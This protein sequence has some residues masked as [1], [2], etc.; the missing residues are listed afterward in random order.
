MGG[1]NE[2]SA[3]FATRNPWDLSRVPGGSSGGSAAAVAARM[4]PL[5]LG[6]DTGGSIRGPAALCGITGLKPTYGRVSRYGVMPRAW[7]LDHVGPIARSARD[8]ARLLA[9]IAGP[10]ANDSTASGRPVPRSDA[11]FGSKRI[12]GIAIGVPGDAALGD[13]HPEIAAALV[14]ARRTLERLGAAVRTVPFANWD[15][16]FQVADT[17][18]K[19]EAASLHRQWMKERRNDYGESTRMR[20]EAGLYIPATQYIDA[21]RLRTVLTER[22]L[23]ETMAGIDLLYLPLIPFPIPTLEETDTEGK[24]GKAVL[25][26]VGGITRYTQPVSLLGLPAISVPCGFC[27]R[28]LPIAFQLVGH[29]FDEATLLRVTDV[30]Q[31]ATDF[32]RQAP[33]LGG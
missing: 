6:S 2:N 8:C 23:R 24:G 18:I 29:P 27:R 22:F 15:K 1:S 4:A 10:D 5:A 32:H 28:S 11:I 20:F 26:V 16:L 25:K 7:S 19:C 9:V 31:Q 33:T 12:E 21:L 14:E 13:V 17:I 3:F 30:Y